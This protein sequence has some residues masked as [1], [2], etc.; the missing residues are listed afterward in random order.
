MYINKK[1]I[2][3]LKGWLVPKSGKK[4]LTIGF[5]LIYF[6]SNFAVMTNLITS[7]K[8][9]SRK[10]IMQDPDTSLLKNFLKLSRNLTLLGKWLLCLFIEANVP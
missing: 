1:C 10:L 5:G 8:K 7:V 3:C 9:S 2:S 4:I 6:C